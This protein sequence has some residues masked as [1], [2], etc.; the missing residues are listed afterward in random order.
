MVNRIRLTLCAAALFLLQT[1][2]LPRFSYGPLRPDVLMVLVAYL[3]LE[4]DPAGALWGAFLLGLLRDMGSGMHPGASALVFLPA[5]AAVLH[6]RGF[7]LRDSFL[8]DFSL[9]AAY[10]VFVGTFTAVATAV[11]VRSPAPAHLLLRGLGQAAF[12]TAVSP[13]LFWAFAHAGIVDTSSRMF[14]HEG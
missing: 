13:L 14:A 1:T 12:T 7:F 8:T 5:T 2:V 3:A 9:A 4:A 10:A 6:L 11:F